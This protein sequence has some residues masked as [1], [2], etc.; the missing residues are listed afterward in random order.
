M[1][2]GMQ[3]AVGD[4]MKTALGNFMVYRDFY[5]SENPG[6]TNMYYTLLEIHDACVLE[7]PI[8]SL[9]WVVDEV[10]PLCMSELVPI[11]PR[12]LDG[13]LVDV[14]PYRLSTPPP[15]VFERW[16][17]PLTTDDCDRLSIAHRFAG[18]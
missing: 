10:V 1:N 4:A 18:H 8:H 17:V 16:S 7:V 14:S 9:E 5:K 13:T 2:F 6:T 12:R 3:A 11:T 15:D